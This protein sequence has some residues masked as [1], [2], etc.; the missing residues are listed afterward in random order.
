MNNGYFGDSAIAMDN[1]IVPLRNVYPGGSGATLATIGSPSSPD[2]T[3]YSPT[4]G[5]SGGGTVLTG[6]VQPVDTSVGGHPLT[7]WLGLAVIVGIIFYTARKTGSEGEFSNIR[8][9]TFNIAMITFIAILGLTLAKIFAVKI[10]RV[11]G[12][13]GLSSIIIAA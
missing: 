9:S 3:M 13:A 1:N 5:A 10:A 7:W 8:A 12:L 2:A 4:G 11:P 6:T